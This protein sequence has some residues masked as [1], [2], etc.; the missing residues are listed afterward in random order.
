[1]R[2]FRRI[3]VSSVISFL[4]VT[5]SLCFELSA[6]TQVD[7]LSQVKPVLAERCLACHGV[8]K[9]EGGLR[10]DTAALAQKGGDS[11][12]AIVPGDS[13]ASHIYARVTS[14]DESDRMPQEGDPLKPEQIAVLKAWIEQNATAPVDEQ[15]EKDPR[16]HWAFRP[17]VRPE[18]PTETN[19]DQ[20]HDWSRNAI[21]AFIQRSH[22]EHGLTPQFEADRATLVRRLYIDLIGMP[23]TT[24]ELASIDSDSGPDWYEKLML[25][26]LEDRR[27]GERWARHWMDIWRYSDWWGLG[28]QLRNSQQHMWH[29]RDWI[30]ESLNEN[31]PYDEMVRQML[32]ADEIYPDDLGKLRATGLLARNYF[33]FNRN[34]WMEETVEHV[35]K[36]FLGL[37]MNCAKCHD[38]KFDPITQEDFYAM[39]AFFEPYH[40]R[41]DMVPGEVDLARDGIPR[42]FDSLIDTPTYVYVRGQESQ[43]DKSKV[44]PPRVPQLLAFKELAVEKVALPVRAWQPERQPWVLDNHIAAARNN[45]VKA[46]AA[47][48][49]A[50]KK[51][52][53]ASEKLH[54][55][56]QHAESVA[57]KAKPL[58]SGSDRAE[59]RVNDSFVTMGE[60]RWKLLG[61]DWVHEA[62]RLEQRRDG[63]D[64]AALRFLPD[65]SQDFDATL[66]FTI[67]GGSQW[68]SVGIEFD[69]SGDP[70]SALQHDSQL[71]YMSGYAGGSKIQAAYGRSG[72][73][74]YPPDGAR[75]L[76]ISLD[77]EY[78]LR[79]QVR[80]DVINAYVD[81]KLELVYRTP[82]PRTRG[83]LQFITFDALAVF[84]EVSVASLASDIELVLPTNGNGATPTTVES[85]QL[86]LTQVKSELSVAQLSLDVSRAELKSVQ[87]RSAAMQAAWIAESAASTDDVTK[88]AASEA[89]TNAIKSKRIV[90][91]ARAKQNVAAVELRLLRAT[92]EQKS[93]IESELNTARETLNKAEQLA[94]SEVK[95]DD[96]FTA[97]YGAKWTP[98][99]FLSSTG[100]DPTVSF[101]AES[102][103]R[104]RAL[105]EWIT[106]R[107]NPLTARVAVNHIWARHMGKPLVATVFDFG[108]KGSPPSNPELLDW[109]AAEL[110]DSN[111][112]MKHIHRLIVNSATYR[113]ASS[114][115]GAHS[116]VERDPD[117][118]YW[119]RRV[120]IRLESQV[121]RDSILSLAGTL[122]LTSFGPSVPIANQSDS[123]RRSLYF[124]HSNNERNLFL[125]LFD[126]ALV[127]ECYQRDQSIVP[128][129]AL[130]LVNSKMVLDAS[131]R[132]AE[133]I[134]SETA[135]RENPLDDE[136][137]VRRAFSRIL[138][139]T[140]NEK[141][142]NASLRA[143]QR[144]KS[145]D[146]GS[147][148]A[149]RTNLVWTLLNHNDFVTL[150]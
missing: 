109:L 5:L 70:A 18:V 71:I 57:K 108:R 144:W 64:R 130:A 105:A 141:E 41:L 88:T 12:P 29:W 47:L 90:T 1:M 78:T 132:I 43:P 86:S 37:T 3:L 81:G 95:P 85:A 83:V 24:D 23:P 51:V 49:D 113:M 149:A 96:T 73:W 62:G 33:L 119:W 126:E 7:Y 117:N 56:T 75:T 2:A 25:R 46:E 66:R 14:T 32:A 9:Q 4:I 102:S 36:A 26:L 114:S 45:I 40:V 65:L 104:R 80:G 19:P 134:G 133:R 100:D 93:A 69:A 147:A 58:T 27:H 79:V 76:P 128:Q 59:E 16:E 122:D 138:N 74:E 148:E 107:R 121:V 82:Q 77:H 127:K 48:A 63:P 55:L 22:R 142:L 13:L 111:W 112:D 35:N 115:A 11:G 21:D 10:L 97:L 124:F 145:V 6:Q 84:H 30:I 68:R 34:P 38:H 106:D 150:R 125:S 101:V 89:K 42:V 143:M 20:T 136:D 129:Q 110:I 131:A 60:S 135:S 61:G 123:T 44:I 17:I 137:F 39:R 98:T 54:E 91:V 87:E 67:R 146:G 118:Y 31:T 28:D 103:G 120:P 15:P 52:D 8:L 50:Q 139:I 92:V 94:A 53:A 72:N 140:A 99:R 116:N